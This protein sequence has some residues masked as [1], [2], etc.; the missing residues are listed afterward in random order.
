[1][2]WASRTIAAT[3]YVI[4]ISVTAGATMSQRFGPAR[5]PHLFDDYGGTP[6][7]SVA[8]GIG[9]TDAEL[10]NLVDMLA[11]GGVAER[12]STAL[13]IIRNSGG[14]ESVLRGALFHLRGVRNEEIKQA[15]R[16]ARAVEAEPVGGNELLGKLL[17]LNPSSQGGGGAG[18]AG[19]RAAMMVMCLLTALDSLD[20]LAGY[21][22][23]IDF[24]VRHAGLFRHEI[25][26]MLTAHGI[27]VMPALI[28]SRGSENEE[29]HMFAVKW[30]RD[31]GNPLL[32]EQVKIR[33]PRRL[34]QLLEAYASVNDLDA[35]DITLSMTNHGSSIVRRAARASLE[36]YGRNALWPVRR[37]YENTFGK[38]PT[39]NRSVEQLVK[40]IYRHF[41][42]LRLTKLTELFEKGLEARRMQDYEAMDDMFRLVLRQDPVFPRRGEMATAYR[43]LA[44]KNEA[45]GDYEQATLLYRMALRLVTDDWEFANETRGRLAWM[46]LEALRHGGVLDID[47]H[48]EAAELV[49][50]DR[51]ALSTVEELSG[52]IVSLETLLYKTSLVALVVFLTLVLV[53]RR[54]RG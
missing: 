11:A 2:S 51:L 32:S 22:V 10:K 19:I 29:I 52:R 24:S 49:G 42:T 23:M 26:R 43:E 9:L 31:L 33:N 30:I 3:V 1:M 38:E 35:I 25:G 41:D 44:E 4:T 18:G 16:D 5:D 28:Y 7:V 50:S 36:S 34:S 20:T 6:D 48:R 17:F 47:S 37:L 45:A 46:R 40:E 15:L 13:G 14:S 54:V 39:A 27:A 21:K 8:P 12:R 53:V